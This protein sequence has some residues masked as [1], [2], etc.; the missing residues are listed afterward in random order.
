MDHIISNL[1]IYPTNNKQGIKFINDDNGNDS[2]DEND[3]D[4]GA[5]ILMNGN[6]WNIEREYWHSWQKPLTVNLQVFVV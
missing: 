4:G 6:D 5:V 1:L 3:N 2:Q